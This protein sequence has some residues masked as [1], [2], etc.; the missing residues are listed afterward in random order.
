[1]RIYDIPVP[2]P[3]NAT[4]NPK[5]GIFAQYDLGTRYMAI[6][7]GYIKKL[8]KS[9]FDD[10]VYAAG[11]F[12]TTLTH[13]IAAEHAG[14]CLFALYTKNEDSTQRY[15]S[16]KFMEKCLPYIKPLT[17]SQWYI[18]TRDRLKL[19]VTCPHKSY[20][21]IISPPFS[22]F[23]LQESCIGFSARVKLFAP[24]KTL[25]SADQKLK[26]FE[27]HWVSRRS[28]IDYRIF[29]N[30]S[31][32]V[33]KIIPERIHKSPD[34]IEGILVSLDSNLMGELQYPESKEFLSGLKSLSK[35][36]SIIKHVSISAVSLI[37]TIGFILALWQMCVFA[38]VWSGLKHC[39]Q[40]GDEPGCIV[41][42]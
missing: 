7:G 35:L 19:A 10:C 8:T 37:S 26:L 16:V 25:G 31:P 22:I 28:N 11:R 12:C 24:M 14:S 32:H 5:I 20:R 3:E 21:Q 6:L 29:N 33:M 18:A 2:L 38:F 41:R 36:K 30:F 9:E 27:T 23:S 42:Y 1:M 40:S 4:K 34:G 13:M 15:C 17:D 39:R